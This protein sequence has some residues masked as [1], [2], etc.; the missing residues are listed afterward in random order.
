MAR[1]S[2]IFSI[3]N[4]HGLKA[5]VDRF[6]M[7]GAIGAPRIIAIKSITPKTITTKC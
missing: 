5:R 3:A 4:P 6:A 7:A 2:A 1:I